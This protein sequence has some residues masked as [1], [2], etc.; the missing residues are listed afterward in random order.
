MHFGDRPVVPVHRCPRI[1][2]RFRQNATWARWFHQRSWSR[3]RADYSFRSPWLGRARLDSLPA[4]ECGSAR[5]GAMLGAARSRSEMTHEEA[6]PGGAFEIRNRDMRA[7]IDVHGFLGRAEGIEERDAALARR[8]GVLPLKD[9]LKR[10][11]NRLGGILEGGLPE[12]RPASPNTAHLMRGSLA[13]N[14]MPIA[15]PME[16][17]QYPTRSCRPT[18]ARVW[19]ASRAAF[20]SGTAFWVRSAMVFSMSAEKLVPGSPRT[21]APTSAASLAAC[22]RLMRSPCPGASIASTA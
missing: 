11:G 22:S 18:N 3:C 20:H 16:T 10:N 5:A 17:P 15:V 2:P 21:R 9:E 4:A 6:L 8:H 7:G 14:G 19:T 13:T 1:S 12:R